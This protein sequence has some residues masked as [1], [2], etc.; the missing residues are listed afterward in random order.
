[1][2]ET[3][4]SLV[5]AVGRVKRLTES[6]FTE[7]QAETPAEEQ[8]AVLNAHLATKADIAKVGAHLPS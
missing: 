5:D 8:V 7:K 1:M 3:G 4:F 2:V 6:G